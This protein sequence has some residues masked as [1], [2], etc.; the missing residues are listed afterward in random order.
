MQHA[1]LA[2]E[3]DGSTT[4]GIKIEKQN[5]SRQQKRYTSRLWELRRFS[6]SEIREISKEISGSSF[7]RKKFLEETPHCLITAH[8]QIVTKSF[9]SAHVT[10]EWHLVIL[11]GITDT[12]A[13]SLCHWKTSE[14]LSLSSQWSHRATT[15]PSTSLIIHRPRQG[16]NSNKWYLHYNYL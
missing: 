6:D 12:Q 1:T 11:M 2:L 14:S 16:H 15:R 5:S 13:Q 4:A 9:L 8:A 7:L 10:K 3:R